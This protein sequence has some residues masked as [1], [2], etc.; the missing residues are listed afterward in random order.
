MGPKNTSVEVLE[1]GYSY[2]PGRG[3]RVYL[4]AKVKVQ[5]ETSTYTVRD[6]AGNKTDKVI[7]RFR[8]GDEGW[9]RAAYVEYTK[10]KGLTQ[11][12]FLN[13]GV[14]S[15]FK[16]GD[17]VQFANGLQKD[18]DHRYK[19]TKVLADHQVQLEI[20]GVGMQRERISNLKP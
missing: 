3:F 1:S 17:F 13:F 10:E 2:S 5:S 6:N 20:P 11:T 7:V 14:L 4:M 16:V 12:E 9:I 8:K 15:N 19:I 18:G